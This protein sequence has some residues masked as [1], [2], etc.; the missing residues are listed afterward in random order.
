MQ[1]FS[2]EADEKEGRGSEVRNSWAKHRPIS[3]L[4]SRTFQSLIEQD[5]ACDQTA[6][7]HTPAHPLCELGAAHVPAQQ[8]Q[9]HAQPSSWISQVMKNHHF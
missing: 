5:T 7:Q 3:G 9:G 2:E 6:G 4:C 8:Q 1:Q